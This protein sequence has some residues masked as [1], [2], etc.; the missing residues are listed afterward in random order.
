MAVTLLLV[1]IILEVLVLATYYVKYGSPKFTFGRIRV[2]ESPGFFGYGKS[3]AEYYEIYKD[4]DRLQC[5]DVL[6]EMGRTAF[7]NAL[8]TFLDEMN[9]FSKD[10]F[11]YL[12]MT[13]F[14][15]NYLSRPFTLVILKDGSW[16]AKDAKKRMANWGKYSDYVDEQC[17]FPET[18][19]PKGKKLSGDGLDGRS[20]G[21]TMTF[22]SKAENTLL[23]SP[24]PNTR[25]GYTNFA[26]IS[27]FL[28][29][30]SPAKRKSLF[31]KIQLEL[32]LYLETPEGQA[33]VPMF[34]NTHGLDI[35]WLHVRLETPLPKHYAELKNWYDKMP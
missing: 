5:G 10:S 28:H 4:G 33:G 26:D 2:E 6:D 24:C 8:T 21:L 14:Q 30:A 17:L 35:P 31:R 11:Y 16:S 13:P 34:V 3:V 32:F 29:N 12:L 19:E 7:I 1:C 9:P 18:S 27:T 20:K 23:I 25:S 22:R 15:N